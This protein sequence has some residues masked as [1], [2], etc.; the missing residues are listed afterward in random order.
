MQDG[1]AHPWSPEDLKDSGSAAV[2]ETWAVCLLQ[3]LPLATEVHPAQG[4]ILFLG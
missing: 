2:W 4:H 1:L 3:K